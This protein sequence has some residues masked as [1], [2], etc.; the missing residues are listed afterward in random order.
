[1][2]ITSEYARLGDTLWFPKT[3]SLFV[4]FNI[5]ER[6]TTGFFGKKTT[7]Y[8]NVKINQSIPDT[9]SKIAERVR[10]N[11]GALQQ[12]ELFWQDARPVNL[13]P[14]EAAIYQMVDSVQKVPIY[15]TFFDIVNMTYLLSY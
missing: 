14:K 5:T 6:K 10:V 13:T 15:K 8:S 7:N 4:D 1:M 2:V 3:S 9:I 12:N 11:E